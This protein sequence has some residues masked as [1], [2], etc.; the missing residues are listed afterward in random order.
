[1][2]LENL[3]SLIRES[4]KDYISEID[5][6]AEIAG[7]A[8]R[9]NKTLEAIEAR[10][11]KLNNLE[12]SDLRELMDDTKIK[13]L[14]NEI[15]ELEKAEKKFRTLAEKRAAKKAKKSAPKEEDVVT[16]TEIDEAP[17]GAE[18]VMAE[19]DLE[20]AKKKNKSGKNTFN[21]K[22]I[23]PYERDNPFDKGKTKH[24]PMD[25]DAI[26]ES[27][28]KMQKLAGVITESEYNRKKSL[29]E[30]TLFLGPL[31]D[32]SKEEA[33]AWME[34]NTKN[35]KEFTDAE[36]N[37]MDLADA[38]KLFQRTKSVGWNVPANQKLLNKLYNKIK[39]EDPTFL[40]TK[41]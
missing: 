21:A 36:I 8:A 12:E 35:Y 1:M 7:N 5:E 6:A 23:E 27:F 9:I 13:E 10:K 15:K 28:L 39:K 26:N 16:D 38:K 17:V 32:M 37:D 41:K 20:E 24:Q 18:D 2:K 4:I 29:I 22:N 14:H 11:A 3:R 40:K 25:E 33:K 34:K 30:E 31:N 19:M